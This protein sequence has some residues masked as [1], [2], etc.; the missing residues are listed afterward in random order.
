MTSDR[1]KRYVLVGV[2]GSSLLAVIAAYRS[3]GR[4]STR[5]GVG[6][7]AAGVILSVIAEVQ[8]DLAGALAMLMLTASAFALGGGAWAGITA[9]TTP[10]STDT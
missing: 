7:L 6:A 3:G 2:G 5:I 9:A 10:T 1:A 8:P 4:P